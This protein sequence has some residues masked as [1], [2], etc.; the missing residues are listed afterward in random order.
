MKHVCILLI[1]VSNPLTCLYIHPP[2]LP[3][4]QDYTILLLIFPL[5]S[6]TFNKLS[7]ILHQLFHNIQIHLTSILKL[8]WTCLV[9]VWFLWAQTRNISSNSALLDITSN[10]GDPW[11]KYASTSNFAVS[12]FSIQ[13][14]HAHANTQS[15]Q[16]WKLS[17]I[18]WFW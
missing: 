15:I 2:I 18:V 3:P 6:S 12:H 14:Y 5:N 4:M 11:K 17:K 9:L 10:I 13:C 16:L 7:T 1:A 8:V